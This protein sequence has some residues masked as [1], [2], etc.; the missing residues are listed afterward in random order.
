MFWGCSAGKECKCRLLPLWL[1]TA[2]SG[3][4]CRATVAIRRLLM[5]C[6]SA[7]TQSLRSYCCERLA[8]AE[9]VC[10]TDYRDALRCAN[11]VCTLSLPETI[12]THHLHNVACCPD[13]RTVPRCIKMMACKQQESNMYNDCRLHISHPRV[14]PP[15]HASMAVPR[16]LNNLSRLC[17]AMPLDVHPGNNH[18][19]PPSMNCSFSPYPTPCAYLMYMGGP[20]NKQLHHKRGVVTP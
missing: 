14:P 16:H 5:S 19:G 18:T 3:S 13:L 1:L 20:A 7:Q 2:S 8:N 12:A 9:G 6:M 11:G 4:R 17:C 15:A 10:T